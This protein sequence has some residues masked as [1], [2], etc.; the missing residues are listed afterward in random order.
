MALRC[1]RRSPLDT[2]WKPFWIADTDLQLWLRVEGLEL[3]V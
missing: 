3:G 1:L 2:A